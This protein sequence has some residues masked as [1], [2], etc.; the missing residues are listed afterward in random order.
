MPWRAGKS[1]SRSRVSNSTNSPFI[2][3]CLTFGGTGGCLVRGVEE[4]GGPAAALSVSSEACG[5]SSG[6]VS[7]LLEV[8]AGGEGGPPGEGREMFP[9][10]GGA[11]GRRL[12]SRRSSKPLR[13]WSTS[14]CT[15]CSRSAVRY[16]ARERLGKCS[17]GGR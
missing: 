4:E 15:V 11:S 3:R 5:S 16:S 1:A 17:R 6:S 12:R 2:I 13:L 10:S 14:S 7:Y 9:A 8:L